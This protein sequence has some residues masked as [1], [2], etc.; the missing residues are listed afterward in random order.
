[1]RTIPATGCNSFRQVDGHFTQVKETTAIVSYKG[2]PK[3]PVP[4]DN[5]SVKQAD[6]TGA[7]VDESEDPNK[8]VPVVPW[9]V[10]SNPSN[11]VTRDSF[12]AAFENFTNPYLIPDKP[13]A[14]WVLANDTKSNPLWIDF[15]KPTILDPLRDTN[16]SAIVRCRSPNTPQLCDSMTL[17]SLTIQSTSLMDLSTSSLIAN[18]YST[19]PP[20]LTTSRSVSKHHPPPLTPFYPIHRRPSPNC[21]TVHPIHLHGSDFVILAQNRSTYDPVESPKYFKFNNPARRDVAML[22]GGGY[23]ALAFKPDNPGAWLMHCHIAWH[24]SS[25]ILSLFSFSGVRISTS[26]R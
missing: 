12:T 1:M 4:N 14:H 17:T 25:G 19:P 13:Y 9:E 3:L 22:P 8:L 18:T 20:I 7:C 11:N 26:K 6:I 5:D 23:L 2:S 15:G 10:D 16:F 21:N 24:A